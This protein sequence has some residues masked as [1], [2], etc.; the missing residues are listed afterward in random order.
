MIAIGAVAFEL[1]LMFVKPHFIAL[2]AYLAVLSIY[3]LNYFDRPH[4]YTALLLLIASASLDFLWVILQADVSMSSFSTTG[5][6]KHRAITAHS[7]L[8]S[9]GLST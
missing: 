1:I 2:L 7:K 6:R 5:T 3:L 9:C 8:A 4:V